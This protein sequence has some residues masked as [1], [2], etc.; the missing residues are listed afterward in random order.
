MKQ[1]DKLL[2]DRFRKEVVHELGHMFGLVHCSNPICV[3][4]S[5]TYVEDI[6]Q[7]THSLCSH[8]TGEL[9]MTD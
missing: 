7:K 9:G 5:S 1:D 2:L 6:D 8:C 3:M 4:R